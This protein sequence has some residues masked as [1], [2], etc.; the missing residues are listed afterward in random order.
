VNP[1]CALLAATSADAP[2]LAR[3]EQ[4]CHSHPWTISHFQQSVGA[5]PRGRRT[6]VLRTP[7]PD[8]DPLGGIVAYCVV[9]TVLD[10]AHIHNLAVR[11]DLR[12]RRLARWLLEQILDLVAREGASSVFL[13]VRRSNRAALALYGGLGFLEVGTRRGYY[14]QP[15]EDALVLSRGGEPGASS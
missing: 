4:A 12:R 8:T 9:E 2:A 10:E 1:P 7:A 14:R 11:P 6:F 5:G 13:E 15:V 3:L